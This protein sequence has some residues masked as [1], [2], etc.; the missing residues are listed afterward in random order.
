MTLPWAAGARFN[1]P[2]F[3]GGTGTTRTATASVTGEESVTTPAGTFQTWKVDITG[4]DQTVTMY[5]SKEQAPVLVKLE[6]V[7]QPVA[8]ELTGRR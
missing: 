2:V 8:F 7:G 6:I 5:I 3:S 4:L 1:I